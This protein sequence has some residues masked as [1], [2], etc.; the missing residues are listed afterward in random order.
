MSHFLLF[1]EYFDPEIN[2][3]IQLII[4]TCPRISFDYIGSKAYV[5]SCDTRTLG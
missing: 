3:K 5:I 4:S 2:A 1:Y